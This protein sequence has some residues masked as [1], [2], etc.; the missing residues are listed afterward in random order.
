MILDAVEKGLITPGKT[1]LVDITGGT[2]TGAG[3]Y[4]KSKK[5]SI[6]VGTVQ[7]AESA[8]LS[9]GEKGL[10]Q[11][12][13]IGAGIIPE[14]LDICMLD[15][16]MTE[17]VPSRSLSLEEGLLVGISSGAAFAAALQIAKEPENAGKLIVVIFPSSAECYLS[18]TL[19]TNIKEECEKWPVL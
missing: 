11:I 13:G 18:T 17:T 1:V 3:Q 10:H 7:P 2:V 14:L 16:I 15:C 9:G 5:P 4:Q 19:F 6:Q 12:Q 8:V